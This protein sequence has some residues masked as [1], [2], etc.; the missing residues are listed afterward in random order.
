MRGNY[1]RS[2]PITPSNA[3]GRISRSMDHLCSS[4]TASDNLSPS[5]ALHV[6]VLDKKETK[7]ETT[8]TPNIFQD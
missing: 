3:R 5:I 7:E 6:D 4:P 2:N 8:R 1:I